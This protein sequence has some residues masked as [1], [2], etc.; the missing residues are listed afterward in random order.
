MFKGGKTYAVR[1]EVDDEETF[2]IGK[3]REAKFYERW[4]SVE[5]NGVKGSACV[6]WQY[7]NVQA[8]SKRKNE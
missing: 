8:T 2:Y 6:E 1:V 4:C 5:I 3:S 7:N